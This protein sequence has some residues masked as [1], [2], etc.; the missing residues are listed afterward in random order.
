VLG[1]AESRLSEKGRMPRPFVVVHSGSTTM[2]AEGLSASSAESVVRRA[3]GGGWRDGG[4]RAS[5][6]ARKSEMRCTSR[7]VG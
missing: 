2:M 3:E 6:M 5:C 1:G 7:V 4:R